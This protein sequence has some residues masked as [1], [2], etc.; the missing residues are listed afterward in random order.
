MPVV[1]PQPRCRLAA[2]TRWLA[3][4]ATRLKEAQAVGDVVLALRSSAWSAQAAD[5]PA[6]RGEQSRDL[7]AHWFMLRQLRR[8]FFALRRGCTFRGAWVS[9]IVR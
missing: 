4:D 7:A 9:A 3:S 5:W 1:A 6:I 8:V 2:D